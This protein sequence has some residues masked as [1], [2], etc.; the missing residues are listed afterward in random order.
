MIDPTEMKVL[1]KV[2]FF[3]GLDDEQ[4]SYLVQYIDKESFQKNDLIIKTGSEGDKVYFLLSGKVKVRKILSMNLDY[5]GYKP[6][7]VTEDLGTFD[8]GY[9]FGEMALLGNY[10]RS[11]DV[12]ADED[13]VLFSISKD[14]FDNIVSENK[15]IGSKMLLAFC[16]TLASWIRTYDGKLIE[17]A[18]HRTLI[19][20][21]RTEKKKITALHKI[22]RST[23]FSTV[24]QVLDSILEACMDCLGVEKGSLMIF[25]DGYMSV[26]AA[27]GL[28][29][30]EI[31]DKVQ[32][33]TD[34]SVSG[35]C[36][37]TGQPLLVDDI[38][39]VEGLNAVGEEKKYFNNSLLSM[40][41][42]SLKG[43]TIGVLNVNNKT[44]REIFNE[45]DR[46]MLQDLAQE[47]AA[48]LG[49]DIDRF[50]K[51][52]KTTVLSGNKILSAEKKALPQDLAPLVDFIGTTS[53]YKIIYED[54]VRS[55]N[56]MAGE[57]IRKGHSH[58][59]VVIA[60][61]QSHGKGRLGREWYSPPG[62]NIYMTIVVTPDLQ[63]LADKIPIISLVAS[64][65]VVKAVRN[66]TDLEVWPKWPN[67]VYCSNKKL[68]GILSESIIKGSTLYGLS[69]GIGVNINQ[70]S[71]P[72]ELKDISTS[73]FIETGKKYD[74]GVLIIEILKLFNTYYN[75]FLGNSKA[76]IDEWIQLS[77]TINS[78]VK[79][80]T[81]KGEILGKA[82]GLNDQGMLMLELPDKQIITLASAE[83]FHLSAE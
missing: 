61:A 3:S 7:E 14:A 82:V 62:L 32:E 75:L 50:K 80:V 55:T 64:L 30:F 22:T 74:R 13:C 38:N 77:K 18:Q 34:N 42:I 76:I 56:D 8:P 58:G 16:N 66:I 44:S 35:R 26:D 48:T 67:D 25:K 33:V 79:A 11:A 24:G 73:I 2:S 59:T 52:T 71:F 28:D 17:N 29:K 65:A 70:E 45:E 1:K 57:L 43:E 12:I 63:D 83:I 6:I 47:A 69:T 81:D 72:E 78:N 37:I 10:E 5:L 15:D 60:N 51:H 27:F 4:L 9:H 19:A 41:L 46:T 39:K 49:H 40:P 54:A 23:V 20:M 31:S 36:F 53:D 68:G 21:L